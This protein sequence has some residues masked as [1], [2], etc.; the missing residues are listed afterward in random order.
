MIVRFAIALG[1][2]GVSPWALAQE[3]KRTEPSAKLGLEL[4]FD[5]D[6]TRVEWDKE[7][8]DHENS[9]TEKCVAASPLIN[10][11]GTLSEN[12]SYRVRYAL[13]SDFTG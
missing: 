5:W 8:K 9:L 7:D 6:A 12:T 10:V 11:F 13:Q 1:M 3:E 4:R 2:L